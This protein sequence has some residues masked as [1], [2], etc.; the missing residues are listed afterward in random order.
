MGQ[1]INSS[2]WGLQAYDPLNIIGMSAGSL[3]LNTL[4]Q[5][6]K[7]ASRSFG[8]FWGLD[9][10]SAR[11]QMDGSFVVG[12]YDRAKTIGSPY[13]GTISS[14]PNCPSGLLVTIRDI[15]L[16]FRNGTDQSIF[17]SDNGGTALLAC[18]YPELPVLMDMPRTPQF[19][20]LLASTGM[21]EFSRSRG[22]QWWNVI[23]G[24]DQNIKQL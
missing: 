2:D 14:Q 7:I 22:I 5:A 15:V 24:T 21:I 16:N 9:G 8:Y 10:A 17:P 20:N 3:F 11:D 12:G 13:T 19:S 23:V 1:V 4:Y 18:V 6:G